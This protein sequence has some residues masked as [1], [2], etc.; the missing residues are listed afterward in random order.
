MRYATNATGTWVLTTL[1][2]STFD[3]DGGRGTAIVVHPITDAVHVIG[4][5]NDNTYRDLIHYTN[6]T[7]SWVNTTITNTSLD[8][9][10]DPSMA[11]DGDGN[12]YVAYYCDDSCSD[13]MLARRINGV[14]ESETVAGS[15]ASSGSKYNVGNNPDIVI[16]SQGTIHIVSIK[17]NQNHVYLHSGTPGS[18][19]ETTFTNGGSYWPTVDVDSKDVVHIAYR[20]QSSADLMYITNASGSW[21]TATV[22]E[23][24]DGGY[25]ADMVIDDNDDILVAHIAHGL[26]KLQLT[27]LQGSSQGITVQPIFDISPMLPDGLNMNWRNGTISGTPTEVHVNTCLLYTSP[28]PRDRTRSRMPSSA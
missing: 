15:I 27:T 28:S 26:G 11:M 8:A 3:N 10:H 4:T 7:G 13:L 18:W 21:S 5:I 14:W 16:D 23:G 2:N 12:L 6:E 20:K 25:G 1:G 19:S 17:L 9:G 24:G 22:I